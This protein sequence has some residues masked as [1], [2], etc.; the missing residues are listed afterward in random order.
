MRKSSFIRGSFAGVVRPLNAV[1]R[2]VFSE[3]NVVESLNTF[4]GMKH[5]SF[6]LQTLDQMGKFGV[7]E[8]LKL[9]SG[10]V[11]S[12]WLSSM[13]IHGAETSCVDRV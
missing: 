9:G 6:R 8:S 5:T 3:T 11:L 1:L 12:S 10:L 13:K 7:I 2:D 4:S